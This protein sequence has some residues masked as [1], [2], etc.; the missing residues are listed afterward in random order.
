MRYDILKKSILWRINMNNRSELELIALKGYQNELETFKLRV[1]R[2]CDE[3]EAGLLAC[4]KH[5]FDVG[6][7]EAFKKGKKVATDIKGC[8]YNVD[9][10]LDRVEKKIRSLEVQ[11]TFLR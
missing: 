3:L 2:Y 5:I 10:M 1:G 8:L 4:S 9:V 7:Q 6:S 11:D